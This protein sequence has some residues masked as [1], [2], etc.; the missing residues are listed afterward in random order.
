M[1]E[2][3]NSAA[4]AAKPKATTKA[5]PK[6]AKAAQV[7]EEKPIQQRWGKELTAAGWTAIPN[8]LFEHSQELGLKHLDIV[9]ILHLAGYWWRAGNDPHPTKKTLARKIGVDERTI[10]R[11]I[12]DMEA[13]GYIAR[14]ARLS[15]LGGNLGNSHSFAG[16]IKAAKPYAKQM[17]TTREENKAASETR[18][19][20]KRAVAA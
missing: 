6:A 4:I 3:T 9:I 11:S 8:V 20:R 7:A 2:T 1:M 15:T 17:V 18:P 19:K 10:Q 14:K 13:K 12:A 5:K 16:L